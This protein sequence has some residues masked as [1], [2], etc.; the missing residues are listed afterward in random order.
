LLSNLIK[1]IARE[2]ARLARLET[3][4]SDARRRLGTLKAELAS[5]AAEPEIRIHVPP[6]TGQ[7][8]VPTTSAEKVKLFRSLFR[9]RAD[10]SRRDSRASGLGIID[11]ARAVLSEA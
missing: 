10:V 3:E 8:P 1:S 5:L 7:V 4:Q 6:L 2:E 9:G 11:E